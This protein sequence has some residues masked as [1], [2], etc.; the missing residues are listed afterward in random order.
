M[1]VLSATFA[2]I[3]I[4]RLLK[5]LLGL[6]CQFNAYR[7]FF[8]Q[9]PQ[10]VQ[11][12]LARVA[13]RSTTKIKLSIHFFDVQFGKQSILYCYSRPFTPQRLPSVY[14]LVIFYI[15]TLQRVSFSPPQ[16]P[17]SASYLYCSCYSWFLASCWLFS[18]NFLPPHPRST[19]FYIAF[20]CVLG[21]TLNCIHTE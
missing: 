18:L 16:S 1:S 17:I 13:T 2:T 10:S 15:P 8:S 6:I 3:L 9:Y 20:K 12:S 5:P 4:R 7:H 14:L 11:N 21:M 19:D